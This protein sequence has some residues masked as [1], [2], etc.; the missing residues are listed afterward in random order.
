MKYELI[1]EDEAKFSGAGFDA[2]VFYLGNGE[3]EV[4]VRLSGIEKMGQKKASTKLS[5]ITS[6]ITKKIS[7]NGYFDILYPAEKGSLLELACEGSKKLHKEYSEY[8]MLW[9]CGKTDI[10]ENEAGLVLTSAEEEN[11][12]QEQKDAINVKSAESDIF[13]A[14]LMPY[15]DGMYVYEVEVKESERRKGNGFKYMHSIMNS[16]K[17]APLYLQVG[18]RNIAAFELYKKLGFEVNQEMCYYKG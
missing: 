12:D 11:T 1:S 8:M 10:F 3:A 9:K 7:K 17:D 14:K 16:F 13:K 15:K 6:A 5:R 4:G 2:D 18:S